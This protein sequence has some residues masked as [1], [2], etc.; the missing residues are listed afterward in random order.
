MADT[1]ATL[2]STFG[3]PLWLFIVAFAWS[4]AWKG[5]ALW[6]S[7]RAN[8]PV[9]FVIILFVQTFGILEILYIFLFSKISLDEFGDKKRKKRKR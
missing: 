2:A 9:W 5:Y 1:L 3:I 6:K 8:H 7:A 4:I